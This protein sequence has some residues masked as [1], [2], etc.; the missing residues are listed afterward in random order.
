MRLTSVEMRCW[1]PAFSI[2]N[3]IEAG[4]P[5]DDPAL[6][7]GVRDPFRDDRLGRDN[8]IMHRVLECDAAVA[9][10]TLSKAPEHPERQPLTLAEGI[11][12]LFRDGLQHASDDR[13]GDRDESTNLVDDRIALPALPYF[14]GRSLNPHWASGKAAELA[15]GSAMRPRPPVT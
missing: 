5:A 9:V 11:N 3:R 8:R 7:E 14:H 12:H 1:A 10:P 2:A 6:I 13:P 15:H 4:F